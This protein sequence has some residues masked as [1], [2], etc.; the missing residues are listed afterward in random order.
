MV[1][2]KSFSN[3]ILDPL[4]FILIFTMISPDIQLTTVLHQFAVS[5]CL[6]WGGV[7]GGCAG[8]TSSSQTIHS[9]CPS[10]P[11]YA[12]HKHTRHSTIQCPHLTIQT[13]IKTFSSGHFDL[14]DLVT[15]FSGQ[16]DH[17][18]IALKCPLPYPPITSEISHVRRLFNGDKLLQGD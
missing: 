14:S 3:R 18:T 12:P 9:Q 1:S 11:S 8:V 4:F 17:N 15:L 2:Y 6:Q 7:M 10:S 5:S 16:W 13:K